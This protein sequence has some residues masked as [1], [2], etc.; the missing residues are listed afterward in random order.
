MILFVSLIL[1]ALLSYWFID[2]HTSH[3]CID[4]RVLIFGFLLRRFQY[5]CDLKV[6]LI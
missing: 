1:T 2:R 3:F 4:A 6:I 5:L